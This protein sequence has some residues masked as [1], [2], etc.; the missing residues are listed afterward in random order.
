MIQN[1]NQQ[2]KRTYFITIL[3]L[4]SIFAGS[5]AG[6]VEPP[7]FSQ[8][9]GRY[10]KP[11]AI[12]ISCST[13][14][15]HIYY[16]IDGSQPTTASFS[17]DDQ[18][19]IISQHSCGDSITFS[20]DNDPTPEDEYQ[21]ITYYSAKLR[22]IAVKEGMENSAVAAADF[23][24]DMVD[25]FLNL[26]Y[27]DPPEA[28]GGKH[29]L[30]VY[31]PAGKR[32][33]PVILFIHGGAWRQ[34]D[35][36]LYMELG[37]TL[38]GYYHFTTV[39]ANY[40]LSTDPWNAVHPTHIQDV[41]LAY[42]WVIDH[43]AEYGGD[44]NN[45]YLFGQSAGG[46]LLSLL[47][48]DT[49]YVSNLGKS[50]RD[51][52]GIISMSGAYDMFDLVQFPLN[53]LG[54]TADEVLMYKTLCLNT[55]GSWE[56]DVVDGAS[57]AKFIHPKVPD[58]LIIKLNETDTFKDMP[59]FGQEALNFYDDVL[60]LNGPDV[61]LLQ[62][63]K[64]D[65]PE[66]ILQLDFPGDFDAHYQE[67]YAINTKYWNSVSSQMV[68]H[69][70]QDKPALVQPAFPEHNSY[71][72]PT[73]SITLAWH[74]GV[75]ASCYK[76]RVI[77]E[78]QP[79][80]QDTVIQRLLVDTCFVYNNLTPATNYSW[81]VQANSALGS[82]EW[83]ELR[84]FTTNTETNVQVENHEAIIENFSISAHPN[85]FNSAVNIH[86][87]GLISGNGRSAEITIF[88]ILGRRITTHQIH[89]KNGGTTFTWNPDSHINS[90]MYLISVKSGSDHQVRKILYLK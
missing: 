88:D 39:V 1:Y 22:A 84:Q 18:P 17:Y 72:H 57:P 16:T 83:S 58:F 54:L 14:D 89:L 45:L 49:S 47:V 64:S 71:V 42:S 31:Q 77:A 41:A 65:I 75:D 24:I 23:V 82:G 48:T 87:N 3:F 36:A 59:G 52:Q 6:Q 25:A 85:P 79:G 43:V 61:Q 73:D 69:Y 13:P 74:S 12:T 60:A 15:A 32:N 26:P 10:N 86:I 50:L 20:T 67:I 7:F 35:K 80:E 51:V 28:G 70:V 27:A 76:L 2:T 30:D 62:L 8:P 56:Q 68:A 66:E 34:G 55:F 33:T 38:A 78:T 90:A 11:L 40:Q 9:G 44:L 63:K 19:V 29:L 4:M 53:P 21:P 37:N 81:Q 5:H 46:H